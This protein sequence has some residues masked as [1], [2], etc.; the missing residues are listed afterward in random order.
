MRINL[1]GTI[2]MGSRFL[3]YLRI[4]FVCRFPAFFQERPHRM[5]SGDTGLPLGDGNPH[6]LLAALLL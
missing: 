1:D 5:L 6:S 3:F 4:N 2:S